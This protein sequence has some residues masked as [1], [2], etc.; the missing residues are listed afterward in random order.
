VAGIFGSDDTK[1]VVIKHHAKAFNNSSHL[2]DKIIGISQ[3][4][5]QNTMNRPRQEKAQNTKE[6][7][8]GIVVIRKR[9]AVIPWY[10]P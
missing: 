5:A 4:W 10:H 7:S 2:E 9:Q 6:Y 1:T 8:R 3:L